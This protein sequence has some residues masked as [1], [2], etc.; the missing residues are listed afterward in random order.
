[1]ATISLNGLTGAPDGVRTTLFLMVDYN[2]NT[3][4]WK[5]YMP[6]DN[7]INQYI[8]EKTPTI[9]AD[10]DAKEAIWAN[11]NPTRVITGPEGN[12]TITL[13]KS[14]VV[15]PDDV[16]YYM[17]RAASYPSITDQ[18]D[19]IFKGVTSNEFITMVNTMKAIKT[20]YPKK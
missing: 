6:P 14:D 4:L 20:I 10:I 3:Y 12:T 7:D 13:T 18:L 19:A 16:D 5:I 17:K 1:M 2:A 8:I 11:T 15:K 9:L